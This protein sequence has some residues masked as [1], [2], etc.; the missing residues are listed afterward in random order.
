MVERAGR[1]TE[2]RRI[3]GA[4]RLTGRMK[5]RL[6]QQGKRNEFLK[7]MEK[8]SEA[9]QSNLAVLEKLAALYNE[10]NKDDGLHRSLTR[11]FNLYLAS[12]QYNRAVDVLERILD[13]EPYGQ[14]PSDRLLNLEGH[15]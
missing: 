10:M 7:L 2:A 15:I 1:I 6:F 8:I 3:A 9:D 5:D 14:G 12:E 11:L 13:F 4:L